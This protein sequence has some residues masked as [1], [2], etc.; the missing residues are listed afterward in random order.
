MTRLIGVL[1]VACSAA[2]FGTLAIF[3]RYAYADGM[4]AE[5]IL[6]LRFFLAALCTGALLLLR[7]E[8]APRGRTLWWLMGMGAVGYVGQSF[9]YLNA[10]NYASAGL[11]AL[12]LYLYPI[13]VT[14]LSARFYHERITP[15]KMAA[16]ALAF[17]GT[18]LTVGPASGQWMGIVMAVGAALIYSIYIIVGARV[19]QQESALQS[20]TIIFASAAAVFAGMALARGVQLPASRAGWAAMVGLVVIATIIPAATFLAGLKRIHPATAAMLSALE[21]V[22]TVVL[23]AVLLGEHLQPVTL[24]GGALILAAVLLAAQSELRDA[25]AQQP[26]S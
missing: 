16:L 6:F 24:V 5:T 2:A 19:M 7:R 20:S 13:F 12:L 14:V 21:P 15:R 18:A 26:F 8:G 11:V 1:L 10:L 3:A 17:T 9:L 23:A 22:V 4:N 25:Q